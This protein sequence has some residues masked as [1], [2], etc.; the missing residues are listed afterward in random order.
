M[1]ITAIQNLIAR[2]KNIRCFAAVIRSD[3]GVRTA[4]E[5]QGILAWWWKIVLAL[6]GKPVQAA[7]PPERRF[8]CVADG[9]RFYGWL[10]RALAIVFCAAATFCWVCDSAGCFW[11]LWLAAGGVYLWIIAGLAFT[12]AARLYDSTGGHVWHLVAFLFFVSLFLA[13][14]LMAISLQVRLIGWLPDVANFMITLGAMAFGVGSYVVEL[15][16]LVAGEPMQEAKV[17]S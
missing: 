13:C 16:V 15:A 12:G 8:R 4:F 1:K 11:I 14:T 2:W 9:F 6:H 5:G 7:F 3:E 17:V 10:Y